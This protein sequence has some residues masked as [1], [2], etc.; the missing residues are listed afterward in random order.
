MSD[1]PESVLLLGTEHLLVLRPQPLSGHSVAQDSPQSS[2]APPLTPREDVEE[3]AYQSVSSI[4]VRGSPTYPFGNLPSCRE[5]LVG[6]QNGGTSLVYHPC[7]LM[8]LHSGH[9]GTCGLPISNNLTDHSYHPSRK[10]AFHILPLPIYERR[11]HLKSRR[12][13]QGRKSQLRLPFHHCHWMRCV[14]FHMF[15]GWTSDSFRTSL[16]G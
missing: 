10:P 14:S 6:H 2:L 9:F 12:L 11:R 1:E 5:D 4:S 3:K 13:G 7:L 8:N 16:E 15:H